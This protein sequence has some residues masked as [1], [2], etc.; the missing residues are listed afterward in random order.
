MTKR[1]KMIVTGLS[2]FALVMLTAGASAYITRESLDPKPE[3][4]VSKNATHK[5]EITWNDSQPA[6]AQQQAQNCDD[7]NV[8][9]KVLGGA[10]GGIAG[11]QIGN[12]G[13]QTAATIGGTLG[14]AYLGGEYIPTKNVT[15]K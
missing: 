14:G 8:V 9:G 1:N 7:G 13:G 4:R 6:P 12:G 15:C 10:A 3:V 5:D 11:S 2:V